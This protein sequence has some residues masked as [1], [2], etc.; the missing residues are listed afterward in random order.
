MFST[1]VEM[2]RDMKI[3]PIRKKINQSVETIPEVSD[4]ELAVKNLKI[5]IITVFNVHQKLRERVELGRS[6]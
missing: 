1:Q 3:Q 4:F 5:V 2:Q 6:K